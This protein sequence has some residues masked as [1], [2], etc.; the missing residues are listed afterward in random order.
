MNIKKS[1][2]CVTLFAGISSS[3]MADFS[4]FYLGPQVSYTWMN[5]SWQAQDD[6]NL[7]LASNPDG[8][9][10]G[11]HLGWTFQ[12]DSWVFGIE[13]SYSSA[14]FSD[15]VG[16]AY[17]T[18]VEQ[19]ITVTPLVGYNQDDFLLYAKAGYLSGKV[20][21]D[22]NVDD[23]SWSGSERQSGWTA[24]AGIAYKISEINSLGLEYDFSHMSSTQLSNDEGQADINPININAVSLVYSHYFWQ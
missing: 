16:G 9:G 6:S 13:G 20:E 15:T 18:K 3:A 17:K 12:M 22:A 1:L 23:L 5:T 24:G 21:A 8:F 11:P 14:S 19:L 2:L 4:G 7:T 10:V